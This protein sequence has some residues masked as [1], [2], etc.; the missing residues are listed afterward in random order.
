MKNRTMILFLAVILI[1]GL[2]SYGCGDSHKSS[3]SALPSTG[4]TGTGTDTGTG[5][6]TNTGNGTA[7]A[8]AITLVCAFKAELNLGTSHKQAFGDMVKSTSARIWESTKSQV[9]IQKATIKTG[10]SGDVVIV[11][12]DRTF[13]HGGYSVYGYSDMSTAYVGAQCLTVTLQHELGHALWQLQD[14]YGHTMDCVM[15]ASDGGIYMKAIYCDGGQYDCWGSTKSLLGLS[16][17]GGSGSAPAT[18]IVI[19]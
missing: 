11:S 15:N 14:H 5:T 9:Y 13:M 6:G 19:E 2:M 3:R 1:A 12:P 4:S 18:E 16:D 8:K 10:E 7:G 17:T